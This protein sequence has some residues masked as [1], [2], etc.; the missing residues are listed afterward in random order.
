LGCAIPGFWSPGDI[1]LLVNVSFPL[2]RLKANEPTSILALYRNTSEISPHLRTK[3][4]TKP[5]ASKVSRYLILLTPHLLRQQYYARNPTY[6]RMQAF[7]ASQPCLPAAE[8]MPS[9]HSRTTSLAWS[10]VSVRLVGQLGLVGFKP[11]LLR[12]LHVRSALL[13]LLHG[14]I[15][16]LHVFLSFASVLHAR[17]F[18]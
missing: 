4:R 3:L 18:F 16:F 13:L 11:A 1:F 17:G 6:P 7:S 2:L 8:P 12:H 15:V 9:A 10:G 14:S 5:A